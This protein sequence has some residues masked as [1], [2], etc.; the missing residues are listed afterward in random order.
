MKDRRKYNDLGLMGLT[1]VRFAWEHVMVERGYARS[2]LR[3]CVGGPTP[4]LGAAATRP[5]SRAA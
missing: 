4:W 5:P 1:L 3:A 2:V